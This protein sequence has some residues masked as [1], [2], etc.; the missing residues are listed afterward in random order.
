MKMNILVSIIIPIFNV[1]QY[2]KRTVDSILNQTYKNIEIILVDD[3]SIDNSGIICDEYAKEDNRI[4][5]FHKTN[6]GVSSARNLGITKA[7]GDFICLVDSDDFIRDTYVEDLLKTVLKYKADIVI[8]LFEYGKSDK[9]NLFL[10]K[11][12]ES[13][14]LLNNIEALEYLYNK[15]LSGTMIVPWNKLYSKKL[16]EN[17]KF[18]DDKIHEDEFIVPVLLYYANRIAIINKY[19]YYY[20]QSSGSIMRSEFNIKRLDAVEALEKRIK[21]FED[22]NLIKLKNKTIGLYLHLLFV[23]ICLLNEIENQNL[24]KYKIL[25]INKF[26]NI[27]LHALTLNE[28]GINIKF[29]IIIFYLCPQLGIFLRKMCLSLRRK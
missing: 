5:V 11:D 29:Q 2:L 21:F 20:F 14:T 27:A 17:I 1:E 8:C 23:Y 4:K 19:D 24:K 10:N 7:T 22:K 3:G 16:F 18:P 26:I 6:G 25:L 9:F 15:K 13:V 12:I 28:V